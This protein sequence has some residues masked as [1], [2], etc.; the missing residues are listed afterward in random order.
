MAAKLDISQGRYSTIENAKATPDVLLAQRIAAIF[1]C[2]IGDLWP[3]KG[4]R[5]RATRGS[6]A[7]RVAA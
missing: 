2:E 7:S 1:G 3:A 5:A 6:K 4:K